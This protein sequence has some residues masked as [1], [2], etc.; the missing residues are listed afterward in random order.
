MS[1]RRQQPEPRRCIR[2]QPIPHGLQ[3]RVVPYPKFEEPLGCSSGLGHR[4]RLG[5]YRGR[6]LSFRR[7]TAGRS[8]GGAPFGR[9]RPSP[10]APLAAGL[11]PVGHGGVGVCPRAARAP[12]APVS[13][14]TAFTALG[15]RPRVGR[16]PNGVYPGHVVGAGALAGIGFAVSVFVAGLRLTIA[17]RRR[18]DRDPHRPLLVGVRHRQALT[19]SRWNAAVGLRSSR[20]A[21]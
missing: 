7:G 19:S 5:D 12:T 18:K 1:P 8:R 6:R 15:L 20:R 3:D 2:A 10:R 14:I 11:R 17:C 4:R 21:S 9:C 13:S 16:L